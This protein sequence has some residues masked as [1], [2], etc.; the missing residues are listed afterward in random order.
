VADPLDTLAV[1][2]P[3]VWPG[4]ALA[5]QPS[6]MRV[7]VP[8]GM[9]FAAPL[10]IRPWDDPAKAL[11][12]RNYYGYDAADFHPVRGAP[13]TEPRGGVV[14]LDDDIDG[15]DLAILLRAMGVLVSLNEYAVF[16]HESDATEED[17]YLV[18]LRI[19]CKHGLGMFGAKV[20]GD[21]ERYVQQNR[22][23]GDLVAAFLEH[24]R[25]RWG[26]GMSWELSGTMGGD[27][28]W[29][30][31]SLCF[32]LMVENSWHGVYR[33]WSRAWLVTK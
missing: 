33:V 1:I 4:P 10:V 22:S 24:Q 26:R 23:I 14:Y 17:R 5:V 6:D 20:G 3:S 25:E 16:A 8:Q 27:G 12:R 2:A 29:A 32:G 13:T 7:V 9:A 18:M 19:V 31:E 11:D 30:K 15:K 21:T 28:D